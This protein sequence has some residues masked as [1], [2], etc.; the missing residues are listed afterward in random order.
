MEKTL[1]SAKSTW[2]LIPGLLAIFYNLWLPVELNRGV[3]FGITES[4]GALTIIAF[5]V[6]SS[7]IKREPW[8]KL[9][10]WGLVFLLLFC[11]TFIAYIIMFEM[12]NINISKYDTSIL[13]PFKMNSDLRYMIAKT[14]NANNAILTYGPEEIRKSINESKFD[15]ALTEIIF[16]VTYSLIFEFLTLSFCFFSVKDNK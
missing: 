15:I 14:G 8:P 6:K 7:K 12:Q 5:Q 10:N 2:M 13:L 11:L 16:M 3:V 4:L 9:R 1:K